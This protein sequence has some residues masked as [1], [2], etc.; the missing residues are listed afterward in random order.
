MHK[1]QD[2]GISMINEAELQEA[3]LRK[4]ALNLVSSSVIDLST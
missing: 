4:Q 1:G 3:G 2:R